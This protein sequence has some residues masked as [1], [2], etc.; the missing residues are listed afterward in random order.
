[1]SEI[2][3]H[4]YV[5]RYTHN[6]AMLHCMIVCVCEFDIENASEQLLYVHDDM[7]PIEFL[8]KC[9]HVCGTTT[10]TMYVVQQQQCIA[11]LAWLAGRV[12]L[13][14]MRNTQYNVSDGT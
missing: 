1:M 14:Y 10:T 11:D 3:V 6:V 12:G 7:T 4:T 8:Y 5:H 13:I 2:D 9:I